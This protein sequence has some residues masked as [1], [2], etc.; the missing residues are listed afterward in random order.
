MTILKVDVNHTELLGFIKAVIS[1]L[2]KLAPKSKKKKK[3]VR[4][5]N[6]DLMAKDPR[7]A[8]VQRL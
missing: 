8:I 3:N 4:E 1:V 5:N 7:K 6:S 2:D